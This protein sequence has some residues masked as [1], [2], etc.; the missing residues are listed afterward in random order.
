MKKLLFLFFPVLL[1]SACVTDDDCVAPTLSVNVIGV[2]EAS[3]HTDGVNRVEM[4]EFL[5]NGTLID[6]SGIVTEST[7][8]VTIGGEGFVLDSK[9]W[10]VDEEE[11]TLTFLS[12]FVIASSGIISEQSITSESIINR[13]DYITLVFRQG[14]G[15]FLSRR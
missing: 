4:I 9:N 10:A 12:R 13:C 2:W 15:L 11:Q 14:D 7:S 8:T 5:E 6:D 3:R 1:L